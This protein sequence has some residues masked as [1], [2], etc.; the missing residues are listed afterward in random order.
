MLEPFDTPEPEPY[1]R[2][3]RANWILAGVILAVGAMIFGYVVRSGASDSALLFVGLPILLAAALALLPG[4]NTHGRVFSG[5]TIGLLLVS[6][7]L[8]EGAICVVLA[9]PLVYL[10]VHGVT[11]VLVWA[12]RSSKTYALLPI[13]L[14]LLGTVEGTD[15]DLR[16]HPDQS[17]AVRRVVALTPDEVLARF[18]RG[19]RPAPVR[20]VPLRLLGMPTPEHVAGTGLAPGDRWV[21]GYHGSSHGPGGRLVALVRAHGPGTIEFGFAGDTSITAR[22][23]TWRG[24]VLTWRPVGGGRTEVLLTVSYRRGLDPS[25][26]FGPLQD[27][28]LHEGAGHLLDMLGLS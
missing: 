28:L 24:A 9:A 13:P 10:V 16:L 12:S 27:G 7:A 3:G 2:P 25:W 5:T 17:V 8:Q 18:A 23:F 15:D 14:L 20:S 1:L 11:A 19:P 26:Y 4:R 6:V 22:W 21:F